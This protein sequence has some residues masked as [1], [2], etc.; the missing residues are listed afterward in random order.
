M[1]GT[2]SSGGLEIGISCFTGPH[3]GTGGQKHTH[4]HTEPQCMTPWSIHYVIKYHW[5]REQIRPCNIQ[6]V[7]ISSE[8]QLGDLFTKGLS[9]VISSRLQKK[10]MGWWTHHCSFEGEYGGQATTISSNTYPTTPFL[11]STYRTLL[12]P[13]HSGSVL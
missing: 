7:K 11:Y 3:L 4:T 1:E 12:G 6:L 2:S 10:L 13:C 8:D 5:Y 9:H